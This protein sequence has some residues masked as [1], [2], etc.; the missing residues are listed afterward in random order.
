MVAPR[1]LPSGALFGG[2][3]DASPP[4]PAR[5]LPAGAMFD[6]VPSEGAAAELPA[7]P[8][9]ATSAAPVRYTSSLT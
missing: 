3:D 6:D 7:S 5:G 9:A 1:G 8:T 4:P 2:A